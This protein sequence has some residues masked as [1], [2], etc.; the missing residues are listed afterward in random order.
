MSHDPHRS[1]GLDTAL[2]A[3]REDLAGTGL[4]PG[5]DDELRAAF[6]RTTASVRPGMPAPAAARR[7]AAGPNHAKWRRARA[8]AAAAAALAV[9]ALGMILGSTIRGRD[10][11]VMPAARVEALP[12]AGDV[13]RQPALASS[14][15]QPLLSGPA[16]SPSVSYSIVRVRIPLSALAP[17]TP[18][19]ATIEADVLVGED[20]LASGIRFNPADTVLVSTVSQ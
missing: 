16:Y 2:R 13:A 20:G 11:T 8:P 17:G 1:A 6:R 15:F 18:S 12:A 3:L 19:G 9:A 7:T 5:R 4:P 10:D 14:G